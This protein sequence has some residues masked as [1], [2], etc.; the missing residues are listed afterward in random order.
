MKSVPL[1]TSKPLSK[2]EKAELSALFAEVRA[3]FLKHA[4]HLLNKQTTPHE[5]HH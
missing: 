2:K 1:D 4:P 5:Q 3:M